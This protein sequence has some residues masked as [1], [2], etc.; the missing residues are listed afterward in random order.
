[1]I[2]KWFL[3]S[4]VRQATAMRKHVEKLLCHQ[5]DILKPEAVA[6][7]RGAI[8]DLR[9]ALEQGADKAQLEKLMADL[10]TA[11]NQ[12]LKP[13]PN[14]AWRENVEVLLVALAVAMGIRTFFL[15]PFKIPTGS[16]QPTLFG[17]TSTPDFSRSAS[18]PA[19]V[20]A[21][22]AKLK[23]STGLE[24]IKEWFEGV[25]YVE[26]TAKA[27]GELER[28]NKPFAIAIF[29][30]YQTLVIGGKT[31]L[32]LF[33]PDY[34]GS[35]LEARAGLHPR[36]L[37][38]TGMTLQPGTLY[39]KGEPVVR[40]KVAAGD[41][42]F[43]DRVSFNFRRPERGEIVVFDTHGI[44]NLDPSQQDTFY[45][46]RL[47]GLGDEVLSLSQDYLVSG[48]PTFN[49]ATVPVGHLVINGKPIAVTSPHF[50]NLYS[51]YGATRG[52]KIIPYVDNHYYGHGMIGHLSPGSEFHVGADSYFVMGDNTMNSSD[53]R[54]WGDFPQRQVIGK[55]FFVYWPIT[56][57]FGWS[58]R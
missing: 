51:Y 44:V 40:M 50:A 25:S 53:S 6:G 49:F 55:N 31:H 43:V 2:L 28:V 56:E 42:L 30:I 39:K 11:A 36:V 45:I 8:G 54:Y 37:D 15:Q 7:L 24:R 41:H 38:F 10:E 16:M 4:T 9:Q 29:N 48:V 18:D 33:P 19:A 13:Y 34:G 21:A 27:D 1:M 14:A 23:I 57:R 26:V 52:S 3:S 20:Q 32:I 12:W 17:V 35:T 5:I 58:A 47:V 22:M 46:K